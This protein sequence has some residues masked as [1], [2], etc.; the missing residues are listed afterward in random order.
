MLGDFVQDRGTRLHKDVAALIFAGSIVD[1]IT[2]FTRAGYWT[3]TNFNLD[4]IV[5]TCSSGKSSIALYFETG[6]DNTSLSEDDDALKLLWTPQFVLGAR[7]PADYTV[8]CTVWMRM[9]PHS[10]KSKS[11]RIVRE[12]GK[13][14]WSIAPR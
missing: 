6:G 2:A 9:S 8:W 7:S 5:R 4:G 1:S 12:V 11:L 13:R 10:G 3:A 14:W